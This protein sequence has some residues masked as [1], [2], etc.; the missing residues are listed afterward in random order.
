MNK[1][2]RVTLTPEERTTLE[3]LIQRGSVK[4]GLVAARTLTHARILLKA[5]E[6]AARTAWTDGAIC[7]AL[8]V[9][10]STVAR[11]R[12][13]F[14]E[15]GVEVAL[16]RRP[17][18]HPRR[19][20]LDGVQEAHLLALACSEPPAGQARWTLRLLADQMVQLQYVDSVS[21]ETVRQVLKKVSSSPG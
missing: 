18:Q 7:H 3:Q 9:G 10:L 20:K 21:H 2:Y 6:S 14:V 1:K 19:R 12:Q 17:A 13:A 15:D 16:Q 11:V 5:D 8:D 4:K